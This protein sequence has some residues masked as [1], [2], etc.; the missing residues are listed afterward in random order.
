MKRSTGIKL[1]LMGATTLAVS[2]CGESGEQVAV[3]ESVKQCVEAKVGT[4]AE[5]STAFDRA[6]LEHAE[7]GPRYESKA[8][9]ERDF[10]NGKCEDKPAEPR[11]GGT[12]SYVPF[13]VGYFMGQRA[14]AGTPPQPVY[15]FQGTNEFRTAAGGNLGAATPGLRTVAPGATAQMARPVTVAR[16]G[17]G[18]TSLAM[19]H[20]SAS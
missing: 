3:F 4:D 11:S 6:R 7:K 9:C 18:T 13:M 10:G 12:R 2:A 8:D 16:G 1:V 14:G 5:C 17:F 15:R 19:A 20:S